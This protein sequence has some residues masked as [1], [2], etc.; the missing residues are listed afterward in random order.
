MT[1]AGKY[2]PA[3]TLVLGCGVAGLGKSKAS[4]SD[5]RAWDVRDMSGQV[6]SMGA[7]SVKVDFKED[8]AGQGGYAKESSAE[9]QKA[10]QVTFLKVLKEVDIVICTAAIPGR[11]SH[12][13]ITSDAVA[14]MRA[15]TVMWIWPPSV[16]EIVN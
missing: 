8:G 11:R 13:L 14:A 9:F 7:K 15:G 2:A 5:V 10:Q 1:A 16:A 6:A 12:L 4:G 3:K